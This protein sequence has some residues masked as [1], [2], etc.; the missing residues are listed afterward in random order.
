MNRNLFETRISQKK[1]Q[2]VALSQSEAESPGRI[3]DLTPESDGALF[4]DSELVL[5]NSL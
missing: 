2:I 3:M 1:K 5:K 4:T